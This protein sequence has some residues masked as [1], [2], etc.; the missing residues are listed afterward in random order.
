MWKIAALGAGLAA[1]GAV[2]FNATLAE[3][4]RQATLQDYLAM[5]C[6]GVAETT[7]GHS[8]LAQSLM[9]CWGCYAMAA[10][11]AFLL[12]AAWNMRRQS[13]AARLRKRR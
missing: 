4:G 13:A 5:R 9:H 3:A 1:A 12:F 6:A 11:A 2:K 10:G 7:A 8:V